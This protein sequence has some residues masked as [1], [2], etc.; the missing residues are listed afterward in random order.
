MDLEGIAKTAITVLGSIGTVATPVFGVLSKDKRLRSKIR[1]NL[2]LAEDLEKHAIIK[3]RTP[4][5]AWV[6][7]R[8]ALDVA[9]LTGQP[10]GNP[11][12]PI[13]KGAMSFAI[14]VAI[15]AG[16]WVYDLNR[17]GFSWYSIFPGSLAFVMLF[18]AFGMTL[19]REIPAP[20]SETSEAS[21]ED[22]GDNGS[23]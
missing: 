20:S 13:P 4:A 22:D 16:W 11:K 19:N 3:E 12:K 10:I 15:G 7:A 8:V 6:Y 1:D 18:S 9:K 5:L 23:S 14:L 2:S 21:N 17:G